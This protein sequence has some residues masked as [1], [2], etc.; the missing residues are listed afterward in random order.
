LSDRRLRQTELVTGLAPVSP[1]LPPL[2]VIGQFGGIYI[3]AT[4][5]NGELLVIDQHAAHER[6]LYEQVARWAGAELRSQELIVP[7]ILHRSPKDAAML[8]ELLPALA[9]EGVVIEEFGSDA[10]LVR[11][12]PVIFGRL[13]GTTVIDDLVSDLVTSEPARTVTDRER[14]T[15]IIA[16]RGA[17][18]AGTVCTQEQC[19]RIVNQLR[20]TQSPF[21][22][23]HGRP[24]MIRFSRAELDSMFKRT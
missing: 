21:T 6:I 9:E 13:E 14:I 19:Q 1:A 8:R 3:L 12:V 20:L 2:E 18:K 11:A 16:C 4:T 15:R 5:G 24:T 17:I 10:F 22:C 7:T 23:P